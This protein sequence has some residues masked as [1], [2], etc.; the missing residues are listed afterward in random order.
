MLGCSLFFVTK[1]LFMLGGFCKLFHKVTLTI[2]LHF[3]FL[4][5]FTKLLNNI[6]IVSEVFHH[7]KY[8]AKKKE[9]RYD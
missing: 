7:R 4:A 1:R 5:V 3:W 8:R 2:T 6:I 9:Q